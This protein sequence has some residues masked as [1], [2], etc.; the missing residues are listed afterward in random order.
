M[1]GLREPPQHAGR[2]VR[3]VEDEARLG[4]AG[5]AA[6][7][8][9]N[10]R[11]SVHPRRPLR[12]SLP[13]P[14]RPS[15]TAGTSIVRAASP[16]SGSTTFA[17]NSVRRRPAT[18]VRQPAPRRSTRPTPTRSARAASRIPELAQPPQRPGVE[19]HRPEPAAREAQPDPVADL[20]VL[21]ARDPPD[22]LCRHE[23]QSYR[24]GRPPIKFL[25]PSRW[26]SLCCA[27][28]AGGPT[29]PSRRDDPL[30]ELRSARRPDRAAASR[31]RARGAGPAP[32]E[33]SAPTASRARPA[34][35]AR[36]QR[37][38]SRSCASCLPTDP[39]GRSA[40]PR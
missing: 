32:D 37:C 3:R 14:S 19:Q 20:L 1:Y 12:R 2:E 18:P 36:A 15:T 25:L 30:L 8:R 11:R 40:T 9:S 4:R 38:A 39:P 5:P 29:P 6:S 10:R 31:P 33:R 16:R 27:A 26:A 28:P 23:S 22:R 24:E 13:G 21:V 7:C 17:S 34:D 35:G